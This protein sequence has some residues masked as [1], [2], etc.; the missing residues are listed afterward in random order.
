MA[1]V[2][3]D[4]VLRD[5]IKEIAKKEGRVLT[6]LLDSIISAYLENRMQK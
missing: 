4:T 2:R 3:I 6:P 1:F 5:R